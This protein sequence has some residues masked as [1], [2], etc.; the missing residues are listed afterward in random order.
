MRILI[1]DDDRLSQQILKRHLTRL[2]HEV[3]ALGD[4][5]DALEYLSREFP[6]VAIID[7]M[8]PGLDGPEICRRLRQTSGERYVYVILLTSRDSTVD[9]I[10]GLDSGA[11]DY[12]TKPVNLSEL[13]AR[14]RSGQRILELQQKLI[15][16]RE[17][18]RTQAT[19]DALTGLLNRGAIFD[20]ARREM[21]TANRDGTSLSLLICDVDHF[22]KL[23]D[24]HGHP[25]GDE[26]LREIASRM[27]ASLRASDW[28]GRYG[29]EEFLIVL[30]RATLPQATE[31][32]ERVRR[33]VCSEPMQIAGAPLSVSVSIG[34]VVREPEQPTELAELVALADACLLRAKRQGRNQVIFHG[35]P[36]RNRGDS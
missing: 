28:V 9:L 35:A 17:Q 2:G 13:A 10:A 27:S 14:L 6:D 5:A 22:K 33:N 29:G 31:I 1:A 16:A 21:R 25:A 23:N 34:A 12:M 4:G 24:T 26:A 36:E 19:Y 18:M 15:E 30:P 11:D 32:A 3:F 20:M 8:M 7:W